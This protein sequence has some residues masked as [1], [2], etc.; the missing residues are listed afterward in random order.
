MT[1]D[2]LGHKDPNG[3]YRIPTAYDV[4]TWTDNCTWGDIYDISQQAG[5]T[6]YCKYHNAFD[7]ATVYNDFAITLC[8]ILDTLGVAAVSI[9]PDGLIDKEGKPDHVKLDKLDKIIKWCK[10]SATIMTF[11][12][13]YRYQVAQ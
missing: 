12:Q 10:S 8:S 6:D 4:C 2:Y 5:I 9:H 13:W 3:M 1:V 7:E 11:E